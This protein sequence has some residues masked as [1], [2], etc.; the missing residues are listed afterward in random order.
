MSE[1]VTAVSAKTLFFELEINRLKDAEIEVFLSSAAVVRYKPWL[2]NVRV[3]KP[4]QL[5]DEVERLLHEKSVTGRSAWSRLFDETMAGLRF[6]LHGRELT[7][8]E[9]MTRMSDPKEANR[10]A[11]SKAFAKGRGQY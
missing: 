6:K 8:S 5:S 10:R 4:Y 11:A 1:R 2:E 9:I 7:N 3:H